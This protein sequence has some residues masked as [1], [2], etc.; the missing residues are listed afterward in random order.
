MAEG[1]RITAIVPTKRDAQRATVKVDGQAVATLSQKR[2]AALGL[3]VEQPWNAALAE[4]V[5]EA[6]DFDGAMR[7][8]MNGLSRRAMSQ[9]EVDQKLKRKGRGQ[10]VRARVLERLAELDLLDDEAF[11]RGLIRDMQARQPAGPRLIR[12]KLS[13]KG[14]DRQL[15]D[16]LIDETVEHDAQKQQAIEAARHR[17]PRLLGL[18][19]G[20]QQR[21]LY[22]YLARRGFE[23]E[24]IDR[25]MTAVKDELAG[26]EDPEPL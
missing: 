4:R 10:A 18:E 11:G 3:M 5:Q 8:A 24:V 21:R 19:P 2:I 15:I 12:Q 26:G 6:A 17:V 13:R 16:R 1:S 20:K 25:A 14:L 22:Q 23:P 9:S 7:E